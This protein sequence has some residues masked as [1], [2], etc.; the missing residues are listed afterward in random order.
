[1]L[2]GISIGVCMLSEMSVQSLCV[3]WRLR[4][5]K[6]VWETR[7]M[8][9]MRMLKSWGGRK[10]TACWVSGR[11]VDRSLDEVEVSPLRAVISRVRRV[12]AFLSLV[13][14]I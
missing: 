8:L 12:D 2:V 5:G 10:G 4:A 13:E 3:C 14:L 1:M 9:R 11:F 7:G 6:D